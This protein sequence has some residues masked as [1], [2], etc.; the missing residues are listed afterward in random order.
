[1]SSYYLCMLLGNSSLLQTWLWHD[2]KHLIIS[3]NGLDHFYQKAGLLKFLPAMS[4]NITQ[5]QLKKNKQKTQICRCWKK[6]LGLV[7][8]LVSHI[9]NGAGLC[10]DRSD[11]NPKKMNF[12]RLVP[13][14]TDGDWRCERL[15]PSD[16]NSQVKSEH[17]RLGLSCILD[18]L[19]TSG[20]LQEQCHCLRRCSGSHKSV[21][22]PTETPN[23]PTNHDYTQ[24]ED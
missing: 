3:K 6:C 19:S 18:H 4:N 5:A 20:H 10:N 23:S 11:A 14:W 24:T 22:W 21:L 12:D 17:L 16:W 15:K 1:M 7:V 2:T 8:W 9:Y 13:A